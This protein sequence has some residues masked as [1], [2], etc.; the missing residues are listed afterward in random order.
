ML[1]TNHYYYNKYKLQI[2]TKSNLIEQLNKSIDSARVARHPVNTHVGK[3]P[4][5]HYTGACL[6]YQRH[7]LG[8]VV[9][10]KEIFCAKY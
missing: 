3:T 10:V 8:G 1:K 5:F 9:T 2:L 7:V 6:H 4:L